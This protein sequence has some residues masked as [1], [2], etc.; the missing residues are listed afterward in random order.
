M[1]GCDTAIGR[2]DQFVKVEVTCGALVFNKN[3]L[4]K[5]SKKMHF[6]LYGLKLHCVL[7][8]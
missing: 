1:P 6:T 8:E 4:C 7:V 5:A 3:L 2:L